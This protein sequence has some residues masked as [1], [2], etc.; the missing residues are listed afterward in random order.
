MKLLLLGGTSE[1][2]QMAAR[3]HQRGV[4]VIYSVAGLVRQPELACSLVSG[5]FSQRGG[6]PLYIE[7]QAITAILDMT[8]PYAEQMTQTATQVAKQLALPYWRYQRPAWQPDSDDQWHYAASYQTL[9]PA[10]AGQKAVLWTSGQLPSWLLAAMAADRSVQHIVR[11]A[12]APLALLQA[13]PEHITWVEAIGPF[14]LAQECD[15]LARHQVTALV[16]KDSGGKT[17]ASKLIAARQ[18]R[19]PVFLLTR[20]SAP[21]LGKIFDELDDC[22]NTITQHFLA[23]G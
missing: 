12:V 23:A 15:L 7:Q 18:Q 17:L 21:L 8:H 2:K 11:T 4:K 1:A 22:E 3:L 6:L 5:G 16:S 19:L 13:L 14:S 10:L 9:W 20:P